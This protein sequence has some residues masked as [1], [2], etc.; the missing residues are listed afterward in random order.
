V[1]N[2]EQKIGIFGIIS[3]STI[4]LFKLIFGIFSS[5]I[6]VIGDGI[7]NITD[8]LSS[9]LV[10]LGNKLSLKPADKEHP[11]GHQRIESIFG[12]LISFVILFTAIEL[13]R[14]SIGEI[15]NP[16]LVN[17]PIYMYLALIVSVLVKSIQLLIYYKG[18]KQLKNLNIKA[19]FFDA[20]FDI[21]STVVIG[22]SLFISEKVGINLDGYLGI[23]IG[24]LMIYAGIKLFIEISDPLIGVPISKEVLN[25]IITDINSFDKVLGYHDIIAH[26]Y[27]KSHVFFSIHIE[28]DSS[29]SFD[30]AHE[31]I[32]DIEKL[33]IKKYH[34]NFVLHPD[35]VVLHNEKTDRFKNS[36]EII[37]KEL[38]LSFHDLRC[39][40]GIENRYLFDIQIPF[41][42]KYSNIEIES[43]INSKLKAEYNNLE[44]IISFKNE[45]V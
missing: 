4:G 44:I 45:Y 35:P 29:L 12:F 13:I 8:S 5:S 6:S 24:L 43:I 10:Y 26:N 15:I 30:D 28:L 16:P 41:D 17:Y 9:F 34:Y 1:K 38:N 37:T 33:L 21:L 25:L 42:C 31:Y 18:F 40:D 39:V 14:N 7:N 3:N 23:L 11:F 22:I 2:K 19:A 27:G 32:D 36:L 20:F